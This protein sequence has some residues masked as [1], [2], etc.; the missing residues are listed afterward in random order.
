MKNYYLF[1]LSLILFTNCQ[2]YDIDKNSLG[3]TQ[4]QNDFLE[5]K[6]ISFGEAINLEPIL[7][8]L[9]RVEH[10]TNK[11]KDN[12]LNDIEIVGKEGS[13]IS[14]GIDDYYTF[15]ITRNNSTRIENLILKVQYGAKKKKYAT[16]IASYD[17]TLFDKINLEK[18]GKVDLVS[19]IQILPISLDK[20]T[21]LVGQKSS[22]RCYEIIKTTETEISRG[23]GWD[24]PVYRII[25]IPCESGGGEGEIIPENTAGDDY[26]NQFPESSFGGDG[27]DFGGGGNEAGS[28][29]PNSPEEIDFNDTGLYTTPILRLDIIGELGELLQ[30]G[31]Y[32]TPQ[33]QYL[34]NDASIDEVVELLNFIEEGQK[35][36]EVKAQA[37]MTI[38]AN[39]AKNGWDFSR[40]GTVYNL[41]SLKYKAAFNPNKGEIMYLL[42][43]GLV[44]YQPS[45]PIAINQN[46]IQGTIGSSEVPTDGYNYIHNYDNSNWYEYRKAPNA[47]YASADID[48]LLTAFWNKVKIIGRYATP[49]EDAIILIDGKDFD[50]VEQ[51]KV[52]TAGFM[53]VG[54]IPGGKITKAFKPI[55]KVLKGSEIARNGWKI[56]AKSGNKT[57]NLS[58]KVVNGLVEFGSR[59]KLADIIN[60]TTLEEAHH[61]LPWNKLNNEVIQEAAYAGFHMNSK[62]NGKALKKYT[63]LTGEGL[64]GNHPAYDKYVQKRLDDFANNNFD[65]NGAK[66]FLEKS[67]IPKLDELIE[68]AKSSNLNLNEYFKQVINPPLGL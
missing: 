22:E 6:K 66:D 12:N 46:N 62:V 35:S 67:L 10:K 5:V 60:T 56:I 19:K 2:K 37:K 32:T 52:Q 58:F 50:G 31:P 43:N 68:L 9:N 33:M 14:D 4:S 57:I 49:I 7:Q 25:E 26:G 27:G 16:Y 59:S 17:L 3:H 36:N 65:S 28:S 39:R 47:T 61:I 53:I 42:E 55:A 1:L 21:I 30:L 54:I 24:I 51:D 29:G 11:F 13:L 63:S 15:Q 23:T 8:T 20:A 18:G 34:L 40:T 48:F 41:P 64:H 45:G 38:D 44:L